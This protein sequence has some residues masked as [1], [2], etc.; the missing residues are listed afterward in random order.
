M[1]VSLSVSSRSVEDPS[2]SCVIASMMGAFWA[3]L[4]SYRPA[5]G[6]SSGAVCISGFSSWL[7]QVMMSCVGRFRPR[8]CPYLCRYPCLPASDDRRVGSKPMQRGLWPFAAMPP[9]SSPTYV[10]QSVAVSAGQDRRRPGCG[11]S[12]SCNVTSSGGVATV[13]RWVVSDEEVG[14]DMTCRSHK[15]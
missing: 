7:E 12:H 15:L 5:R 8:P 10:T 2:S 14:S 6:R 1:V 4:L 13:S 11:S 9:L 3:T